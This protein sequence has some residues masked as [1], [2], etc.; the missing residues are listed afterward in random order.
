MAVSFVAS[1][2]QVGGAGAGVTS[3]VVTKP[4]GTVDGDLV[5]IALDTNTSQTIAWPAGFTQGDLQ[6]GTQSAAHTAAWAWKIASGEGPSWTVTF[7]AAL[8]CSCLAY[9]LRGTATGTPPNKNSKHDAASYVT[10]MPPPAATIANAS[11]A[12][13][14]IYTGFDST[15]SGT[16]TVTLPGLSNPVSIGNASAGDV[17]G[18]VWGIDNSAPGNATASVG[19]DYIDFFIDIAALGSVPTVGTALTVYP[20]GTASA[21]TLTTADTLA[22]SAPAAETSHT[23][24]TGKLLA[25]GELFAQGSTGTWPAGTSEPAPSGHGFI[26]DTTT[27]EGQSIIAGTW[28][29]SIKLSSSSGT[30]TADI[31]FRAYKRTSA[32]VYTQIVDLVKTAAAITATAATYT[33]TAGSGAQTAFATGDKLYLDVVLHITA[34]TSA[35]TT[36]TTSLFQN[37]GAA[38]SMVTPGYTVLGDAAVPVTTAVAATGAVGLASAATALILSVAIVAAGVVGVSS[39]ASVP[40]TTAIAAAGSA[41]ASQPS[42]GASVPVTVAITA[43]GQV[44]VGSGASVPVSVAIAAAGGAGVSSGASVPVA[45]AI[46]ATGVVGTGSGASVPIT[47]TITASG[48]AGVRTGASVPISVA[49]AATGAVSGGS[50]SSGASVPVTVAITATGVVGVRSGASLPIT[51]A[52]ASAGVEGASSGASVP[53]TAAITTSGVVG[54]KTGASV[55]VVVALTATGSVAGGGPAGT[56]IVKTGSRFLVGTQGASGVVL[57]TGNR[58]RVSA[59]GAA[60]SIVVKRLEQLRSIVRGE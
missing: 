5:I 10:A 8:W 37:G 27:L 21:S 38:E 1:S 24:K 34:N 57:K 33:P 29:P 40:I 13:V 48:A 7:G 52:I 56:Y 9:T 50:P 15:S 2:T 47:D 26:L 16:T 23:T 4:T 14:Y 46:T 32:G 42:S 28:T 35:S 44:G 6:H 59:Q 22:T 53:V 51:V 3:L 36:A 60:A 25:W 49:I 45:V 43:T 20:T 41:G 39:G 31:H 12:T 30:V 17:V 55:P 11:D 54:V 18:A 58:F 19:L